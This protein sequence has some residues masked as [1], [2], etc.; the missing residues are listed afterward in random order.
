MHLTFFHHW[1]I[2]AYSSMY[3]ILIVWG[4]CNINMYG[5]YKSG[6]LL[7]LWRQITTFGS[8][9][10]QLVPPPRCCWWANLYQ[11]SYRKFWVFF[12][13]FFSHSMLVPFHKVS[14]GCSLELTADCIRDSMWCFTCRSLHSAEPSCSPSISMCILPPP[15]P[16]SP[17]QRQIAHLSFSL[18]STLLSFHYSSLSPFVLSI[19]MRT[20]FSVCF[21]LLLLSLHQNGHVLCCYSAH[22]S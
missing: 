8:K 3:H 22:T 15:S 1:L 5:D 13:F 12:D 18:Y 20:I 17:A 16:F 14:L 2:S 9:W 10:V 19:I 6:Q 4:H 21:M 7:H 11:T